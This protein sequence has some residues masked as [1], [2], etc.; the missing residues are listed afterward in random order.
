MMSSTRESTS[1]LAS[2]PCHLIA[3]KVSLPSAASCVSDAVCV[4]RVHGSKSLSAQCVLS[5]RSNIKCKRN[6]MHACKAST[7]QRR[8]TS[9]AMRVHHLQIAL[10]DPREL[11]L[12]RAAVQQQRAQ[13][14]DL[15]V[16]RDGQ[17]RALAAVGH[18][19][20]NQAPTRPAPMHHSIGIPPQSCNM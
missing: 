20:A 5:S 15:V 2:L 4:D 13:A 3:C 16:R 18:G 11:H 6:D 1:S 17:R 10:H 8:K 9:S 19:E 12:V 7:K 14:S